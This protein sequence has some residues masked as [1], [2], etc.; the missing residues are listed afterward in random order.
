MKVDSPPDSPG[1]CRNSGIPA[2]SCGFPPEYLDSLDS[3]RILGGISGGMKS[4]ANSDGEDDYTPKYVSLLAYLLSILQSA[5]SSEYASPKKACA[6]EPSTP[7]Q[8][9]KSAFVYFYGPLHAHGSY[10]SKCFVQ[11]Q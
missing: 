9:T 8:S 1:I 7:S 6:K 5:F 10:E 2:H 11:F 3:P 4:I